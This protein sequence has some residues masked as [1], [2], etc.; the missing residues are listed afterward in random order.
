MPA[1]RELRS[2]KL[3]VDLVAKVVEPLVKDLGLHPTKGND[4]GLRDP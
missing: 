4:E 3:R 2:P 1:K